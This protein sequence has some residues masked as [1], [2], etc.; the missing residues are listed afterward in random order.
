[1]AWNT[2]GPA[3]SIPG[4]VGLTA[5]VV[6]PPPSWALVQRQL[7]RTM[8]DAV[9][10]FDRTYAYPGGDQFYTSTLDDAYETRSGRAQLYY[11]GARDDF[12]DAALRDWNATARF[13]D[14]GIVVRDGDPIYHERYVAQTHNEYYNAADLGD[15]DWFHMGEGNQPFYD[16]GVAYP[17]IPENARRAIRFAAMYMGDDPEAPNYDPRYRVIRSPLTGSRGPVLR[18]P[19]E[20][21]ALML[22]PTNAY[23]SPNP[24]KDVLGD[25]A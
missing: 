6:E 23:L 17:A 25:S 24:P 18:A 15:C 21:A 4:M 14:D 2:P 1:M 16:F 22:R 19:W 13:Y 11:V 20:H 3:V 8:E 12:L 10:V 5:T 9:D 7:V